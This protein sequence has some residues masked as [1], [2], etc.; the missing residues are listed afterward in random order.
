MTLR[1]SIGTVVEVR[2]ALRGASRPREVTDGVGRPFAWPGQL[3]LGV[4]D[5][6]GHR[7]GLGCRDWS[8]GGYPKLT[9]I[10]TA[11]ARRGEGIGR[12]VTAALTRHALDES[13]MCT[14]E[15]YSDNVVAARLY[16][17][18]GFDQAVEWRSGPLR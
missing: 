5:P 1:A 6:R 13:S 8:L 11:S 15:H 7:L 14:I 9:G 4:R 10:A 12:S 2:R 17:D 16:R 3:W 18:M